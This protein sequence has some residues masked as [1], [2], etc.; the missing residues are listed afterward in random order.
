MN[1]LVTMVFLTNMWQQFFRN[2]KLERQS[3]FCANLQCLGLQTK[4]IVEWLF[5][6]K[7]GLRSRSLG[8]RYVGFIGVHAHYSFTFKR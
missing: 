4:H 2:D 8:E 1:L 6:L 7:K 3:I 5:H